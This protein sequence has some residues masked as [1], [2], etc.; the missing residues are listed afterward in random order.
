MCGKPSP[1]AVEKLGQAVGYEANVVVARDFAFFNFMV[2]DPEINLAVVV[3]TYAHQYEVAAGI[4]RNGDSVSGNSAKIIYAIV[5]NQIGVLPIV[6][7]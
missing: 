1:Q 6:D 7:G 4:V 2:F 5:F 3:A